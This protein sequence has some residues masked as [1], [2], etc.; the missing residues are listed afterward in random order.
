MRWGDIDGMP[1]CVNGCRIGDA[2]AKVGVHGFQT[3]ELKN[4]GRRVTGRRRH[5]FAMSRRYICHGC[6]RL[7]KKKKDDALAAAAARGEARRAR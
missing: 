4:C 5:Y 6:E 1:P 2:D 7:A 3:G